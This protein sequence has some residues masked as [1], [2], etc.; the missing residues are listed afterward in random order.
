MELFDPVI[1]FAEFI[2]IYDVLGNIAQ[3]AGIV[4]A[5]ILI[6][7]SRVNVYG[8][9]GHRTPDI[10]LGRDPGNLPQG[11]IHRA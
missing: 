7:R 11:I 6:I 3:L 4:Q 1:M 10:Y 9:T 2:D 8:L 5:V